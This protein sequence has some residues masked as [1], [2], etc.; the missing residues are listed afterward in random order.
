MSKEEQRE[1]VQ[2]FLDRLL[3]EGIKP[4][5]KLLTKIFLTN[6][7]AIVVFEPGPELIDH[8]RRI[9]GWKGEPCFR[10][11]TN[12]RKALAATLDE[13]GDSVSARWLLSKRRGRIFLFTGKGSTFLINFRPDKGFSFEPGSLDHEHEPL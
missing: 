7:V 6:A 12:H 9:Y 10:M 8:L 13:I 4:D 5:S 3:N 2:E 1:K 11:I